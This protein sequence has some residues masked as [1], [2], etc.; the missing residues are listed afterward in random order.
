MI[1]QLRQSPM[2]W[3]LVYLRKWT[4]L[5]KRPQQVRCALYGS[6]NA[7]LEVGIHVSGLMSSRTDAEYITE[8]EVA[9]VIEVS[10]VTEIHVTETSEEDATAAT[11]EDVPPVPLHDAHSAPP[12]EGPATSHADEQQ[13][14]SACEPDVKDAASPEEGSPPEEV[15]VPEKATAQETVPQSE[16]TPPP[17]EATGLDDKAPSDGSPDQED[18]PLEPPTETEA[19]PPPPDSAVEH[20]CADPAPEPAADPEQAAD[21][22]DGEETCDSSIGHA[23]DTMLDDVQTGLMHEFGSSDGSSLGGSVGEQ[24]T[25]RD[26]ASPETEDAPGS[27]KVSAKGSGGVAF[28]EPHTNTGENAAD[29]AVSALEGTDSDDAPTCHSSTQGR[30]SVKSRLGLSM[31]RGYTRAPSAV[32][33]RDLDMEI[34]PMDAH[35]AAEDGAEVLEASA[36]QLQAPRDD[37]PEVVP[38]IGPD[39]TM[40]WKADIMRTLRAAGEKAV[41]VETLL[42]MVP[43]PECAAGG[44]YRTQLEEHVIGR[45]L[46]VWAEDGY[47]VQLA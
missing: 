25:A 43:H 9:P 17:A 41:K 39:P 22:L 6:A 29:A 40:A 19:P 13:F 15:N 37:A 47:A 45:G 20:L 34:E 26:M 18:S 38:M 2:K 33:E 28:A 46:A 3:T 16:A 14:A 12:D 35:A 42:G 32:T 4:Q 36:A 31:R 44:E 27:R 1:S 21:P 11:P 5:K 7:T 8:Q 30:G 10:P 23:V 24:N